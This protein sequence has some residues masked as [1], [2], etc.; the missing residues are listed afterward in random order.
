[1]AVPR[2]IP[3]CSQLAA[4]YQFKAEDLIITNGSQQAS[5][6]LADTLRPWYIVIMEAP[7]YFVCTGML[8]TTGVTTHGIPCDHGHERRLPKTISTGCDKQEIK[9]LKAIYTVSYCQN[10]G[11]WTLSLDRAQAV[12]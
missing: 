9:R 10:P 3:N 5:I 8:E 7:T 11:G 6:I 1:M 12:I 2:A 4:R